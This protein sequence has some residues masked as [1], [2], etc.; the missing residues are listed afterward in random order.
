MSRKNIICPNCKTVVEVEKSITENT[1]KHRIVQKSNNSTK[2]L[3]GC[4]IRE[5]P[6]IEL[7]ERIIDLQI[8][9]QYQLRALVQLQD[10][11]KMFTL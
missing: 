4:Y 1:L 5:I 9:T 7:P 11:I 2:K 10:E 6:T 3:E 8:S